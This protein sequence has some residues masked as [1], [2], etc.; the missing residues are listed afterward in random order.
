MVILLKESQNRILH[1]LILLHILY[2]RKISYQNMKITFLEKIMNMSFI[3]NST[4]DF[5]DREMIL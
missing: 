3:W 2:R 5:K 1:P 4:T